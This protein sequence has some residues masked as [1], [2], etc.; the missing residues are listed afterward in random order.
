MRNEKKFDFTTSYRNELLRGI[1]KLS[2]ID[3]ILLSDY[4]K[5][6]LDRDFIG[7]VIAGALVN[8]IVNIMLIPRYGAMGA[9]IGTIVAELTACIWQYVAVSRYIDLR[10]TLLKTS[11]YIFTGIVMFFGVRS[12]AKLDISN[13]VKIILEILTGIV[14]YSCVCMIYWKRTNNSISDI[15][16]KPL[17]NK[18]FKKK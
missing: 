16:L 14:I 11:F 3:A 5:G 8:L 6:T 18:L 15:M 1:K 4:G 7:S 10:I 2:N 12:M 9:V 17:I 13:Y